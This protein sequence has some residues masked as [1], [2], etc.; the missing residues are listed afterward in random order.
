MKNKKLKKDCIYLIIKILA[1]ALI[2]ILTF[3][4]VL[5]F[6]RISGNDMFPSVRAGALLIGYRL[7]K[8]YDR[9]DV[10]LYVRGGEKSVGRIVGLPGDVIN[11]NQSGNLIVNGTNAGLDDLFPTYPEGGIEYP[12]RIPEDSVFIL[13]DHRTQAK[14]SRSFGA[15]KQNTIKAKAITILRRRDL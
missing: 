1:F 7:D 8:K 2:C 6:D 14:D 15:V 13:G 12:F 10:V 4:C 11:L 3:T 9:G 5:S